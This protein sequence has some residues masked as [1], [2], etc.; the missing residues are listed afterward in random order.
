MLHDKES[1]GASR[2]NILPDSGTIVQKRGVTPGLKPSEGQA[3]WIYAP[4]KIWR[5]RSQGTF[6]KLTLGVSIGSS[7]AKYR[8]NKGKDQEA[9]FSVQ[10]FFWMVRWSVFTWSVHV[11]SVHCQ[12]P[13]CAPLFTL[14]NT[15]TWEFF[16]LLR[17]FPNLVGLVSQTRWLRISTQKFAFMRLLWWNNN[18]GGWPVYF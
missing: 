18:L 1:F 9:L 11:W 8:L 16:K 14:R 12:P 3:F 6:K 13:N 10:I 2:R 17:K 4:R 7:I 5:L 15:K